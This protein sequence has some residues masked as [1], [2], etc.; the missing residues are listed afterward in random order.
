M[1]RQAL[2]LPFF[3]DVKLYAIAGVCAAHVLPRNEIVDMSGKGDLAGFLYMQIYL[4]LHVQL[5]HGPSKSHLR[6]PIFYRCR[7]KL[8]LSLVTIHVLL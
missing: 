6:G 4:H 2:C 5:A 1:L 8:L 3:K 7:F